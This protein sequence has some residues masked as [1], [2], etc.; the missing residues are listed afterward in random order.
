MTH[1]YNFVGYELHNKR[2]DTR[3]PQSHA[4]GQGPFLRSLLTH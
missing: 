3:L 1:T 4:V 2:P